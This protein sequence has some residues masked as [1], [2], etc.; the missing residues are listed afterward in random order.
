MPKYRDRV[1]DLYAWLAPFLAVMG[2]KTRHTWA[3]LDLR[4]P[5]KP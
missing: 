5:L 1:R 3:P 2:R 4:G